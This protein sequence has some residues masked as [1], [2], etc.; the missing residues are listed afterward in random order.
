MSSTIAALRTDFARLMRDEPDRERQAE[1]AARLALAAVQAARAHQAI[2]A[3]VAHD[4][5]DALMRILAELERDG[6]PTATR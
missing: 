2:S 6:A 4:L 5:T 1:R 3:D